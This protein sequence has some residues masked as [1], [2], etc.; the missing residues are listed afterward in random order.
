MNMSLL[1]FVAL[2]VS[3]GSF[4]SDDFAV[5]VQAIID[6]ESEGN[7]RA[8]SRSGAIGLMQ[9]MP[10]TGRGECGLTRSQ[11]FDPRLNVRCGS[12]YFQ[13]LLLRYGSA[14][15]AVA[16]YHAGPS[17]CD[18]WM[19]RGF[20]IPPIRATRYHVLKFERA[21]HFRRS[22]QAQRQRYVQTVLGYSVSP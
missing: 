6:V 9:V 11:L 19:R 16:C 8:V 17:T 15:R 18:Y 12:A 20:D 4:A 13:R 7:S 22:Q 1:L 21:V 14:R 10:A 2:G 3:P 5:Y